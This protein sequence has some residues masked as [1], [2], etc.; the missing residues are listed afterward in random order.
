LPLFRYF[1]ASVGAISEPTGSLRPAGN[2]IYSPAETPIAPPYD[3]AEP[4]YGPIPS[5]IGRQQAACIARAETTFVIV[6]LGQS[7]AANFAAGRYSARHDVVNFNVYDGK[8]YRAIDPLVGA[9]GDGGNFATRLGDVLIER[10]F[11]ARVVLAP[12]G[13]GNTRIED[14]S[15]GGIFNQRIRVLVRRLFDAGITPDIILWQQGE[16]NAGDDDPGGRNYTRHLLEVVKTFRNSGIAAPFMIA[17][18]TLCG[19]P[20]PNAGNARAGQRAAVGAE[21]ATFLGPD[22]DQLGHEYRFDGCHMSES[23]VLKQAE[24]WANS[25]MRLLVTR[26]RLRIIGRV[27]RLMRSRDRISR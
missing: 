4:I 12:I 3:G 22:T 27:L 23:G 13:M 10:G 7:N 15:S 11:A 14:W 19:E 16:G 20:H 9:S 26:R 8:C 5:T 2:A 24:M 1:C 18:C 17:L 6:T 21:L 25:I